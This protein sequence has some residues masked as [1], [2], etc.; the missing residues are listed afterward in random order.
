[1]RKRNEAARDAAAMEEGMREYKLLM[2]KD[3]DEDEVVDE[4][5]EEE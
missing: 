3:Y 4:D 2:G 1:M 5:D